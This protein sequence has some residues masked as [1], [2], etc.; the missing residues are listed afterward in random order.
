MCVCIYLPCISLDDIFEF[1]SIYVKINKSDN[2]DFW[3]LF[4]LRARIL[5]SYPYDN[6]FR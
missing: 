5:H 4:F 6:I 2:R 3:V 1:V